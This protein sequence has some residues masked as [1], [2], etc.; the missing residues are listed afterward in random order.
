MYLYSNFFT[1]IFKYKVKCFFMVQKV[2]EI[3]HYVTL[4]LILLLY[5]LIVFDVYKRM[6]L[7]IMGSKWNKCQ[8]L[9]YTVLVGKYNH[10][11]FGQ[12]ESHW[13]ESSITSSRNCSYDRYKYYVWK[14]SII[15]LLLKHNIL[16]KLI[17][18]KLDH[19]YC[20]HLYLEWKGA[21]ELY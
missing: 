13:I 21:Y 8:N 9:I 3:F 11:V 2:K 4:L 16:L 18:D 5:Y 10:I 19:E 17:C 15:V 14:V 6:K 20:A 1:I 12:N 7:N